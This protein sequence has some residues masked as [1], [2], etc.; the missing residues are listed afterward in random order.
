MLSAP[1][2]HSIEASLTAVAGSERGPAASQ[3]TKRLLVWWLDLRRDLRQGD[4]ITA[5]LTFHPDDSEPTLHAL[6]F[7]STKFGRT[8]SAFRHQPE[9]APFARYYDAEGVE[10]EQRLQR[11]PIESYEQ[12][13]S[14]LGDGRG[15]KGV[16]F[17]A[18]V[19]TPIK[20]PFG[21]L[22]V[23]RN[24]G[25]RSNGRCI[26]LEGSNG[27]HAV[28]LHLSK[29]MVKAGQKVRAGEVIGHVGNTGRSTAAHLHY[30]LGRNGRV[31][32]PFR[33][34]ETYR[35]R[36]TGPDRL[37]FQDTLTTWERLRTES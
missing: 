21:G 25:V 18:P 29:V 10:V 16:D 5:V 27:V 8:F 17:K 11:G 14:L 6:W 26:E 4:E 34:H 12:V 2:A 33:F 24:W 1:I 28:F 19:G 15:H 13:T 23:R 20:A 3:V 7:D 31:V 37:A 9:G 30:Q 22:V 36:L 32:D 35:R